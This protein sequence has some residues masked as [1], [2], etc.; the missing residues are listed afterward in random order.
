MESVGRTASW[1]VSG[2]LDLGRT[3]QAMALWGATTWLRVDDTGAWFARRTADGPATLHLRYRD[4]SLSATAYGP[5]AELGL[6]TVP[7]LAGLSSPCLGDLEPQHEVVRRLV[8][9]HPGIRTG[10]SGQVYPR[11]V[12]AALA[13]KVT[14]KNAHI[15]L[16][17]LARAWGEVAP[18]PRSDL[19]LLPEP[20]RL[21]DQPYYAFHQLGIERHRADLIRRIASRASALERAVR[22]PAVE[23]RAHLEKLRGIGPWTSGVVMGG[24][25]GDPDAVPLADYHLPNIVAY[26]LAGERRADDERMMALLEPYAGQRGQLVRQLKG[27]GAKPPRRGPK[28]EVRDIRDW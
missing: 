17:R 14:A 13:Q 6:Q 3:M 15:V 21:R 26:N 23:A 27:G 1:P 10:R 11:L 8:R 12:S 22:M 20:K 16:K 9:T 19:L 7:E 5:G 24:P 25:L 2:P 4:S 28:T 18:G